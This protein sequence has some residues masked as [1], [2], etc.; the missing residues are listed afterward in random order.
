MDL[1]LGRNWEYEN[2]DPYFHHGTKLCL[3]LRFA[4]DGYQ[5]TNSIKTREIGWR[6]VAGARKG[7]R[8]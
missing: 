1:A 3:H 4:Y 8:N 6:K 2:Q 5:R 7:P